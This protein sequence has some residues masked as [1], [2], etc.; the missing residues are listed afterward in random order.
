MSVHGW[1]KM[2]LVYDG[3]IIGHEKEGSHAI[4][5]DLHEPGEYYAKRKRSDGERQILHGIMYMWKLIKKK[6]KGIPGNRE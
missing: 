1:I 3:I 5:N 4:C 6:K 2:A